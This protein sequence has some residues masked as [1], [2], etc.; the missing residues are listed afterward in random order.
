MKNWNVEICVNDTY[1]NI[2]AI[3]ADKEDVVL[4]C[5]RELYDVIT[6]NKMLQ[7]QAK[8]L[9]DKIK[10][11][12]KNIVRKHIEKGSYSY[13]EAKFLLS[14]LESFTVLHFYIVWK[15]LKN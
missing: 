3:S 2:G 6:Y 12:L 8:S 9:L 10:F 4:E 15:I 5:R 14:K 11:D 1:K 7:E 13:Q